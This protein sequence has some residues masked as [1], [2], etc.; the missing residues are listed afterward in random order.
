M[1]ETGRLTARAPR[2]RREPGHAACASPSSSTILVAW[3]ALARSGLLFRDVVPSLLAIGRRSVELLADTDYYWHLG[4]TAR[5]DR[6][7]RC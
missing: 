4:V 2:R 5:R 7:R 6:H 3:E 1:A